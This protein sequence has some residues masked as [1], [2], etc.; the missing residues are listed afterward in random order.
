MISTRA[1]YVVGAAIPIVA[2]YL[3]KLAYGVRAIELELWSSIVTWAT[4]GYW[5]ME[6]DIYQTRAMELEL[7][8]A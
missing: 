5:A 8:V 6:L 3:R 2:A 7:P 1:P 4:G